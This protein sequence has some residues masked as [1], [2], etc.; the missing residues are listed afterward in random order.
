MEPIAHLRRAKEA[1]QGEGSA[2]SRLQAAGNKFWEALLQFER[3][4]PELDAEAERIMNML[5]AKGSIDETV[6]GMDET[7]V[8]ETLQRLSAF[9][10]QAEAIL[11]VGG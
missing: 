8:Q 4:P 7:T 1:V 6:P 11:G 2:R 5:F 3:W 9:C 10:D